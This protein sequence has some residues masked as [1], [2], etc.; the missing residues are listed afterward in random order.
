[1]PSGACVIRYNGARGVVWRLKYADANGR[2]I[3]ETLGREPAWNRRKAERALGARLADVE[4]RLRRPK[5]R[6]FSDLIDEFEAVALPAKP[7]KKSTLV[8]YGVT[9]KNHL[10]PALGHHDLGKLSQS[11]ETFEDTSSTS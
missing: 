3:Q 8:D 2:Q 10:R 1:M 11:P 5:R 4:R 9:I 7:R 6:T